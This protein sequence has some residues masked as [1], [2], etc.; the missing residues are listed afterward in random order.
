MKRT[1]LPTTTLLAF[2]LAGSACGKSNDKP[3]DGVAHANTPPGG[4]SA[5]GGNG[6]AAPPKPRPAGA[7][8]SV[9]NLADNRLLAHVQRNGGV[10]ALMG[11]PG[12]AKYLHFAKPKIT[13]KLKQKLDGKAVATA[14]TY[15]DID[16]PLT[17]DQA[18]AAKTVWVRVHSPAAR[19][20]EVK[21]N[22]K[23]A[24]TLDLAAGWQTAQATL[25]AKAA[26]AGENR[27]Q[28]IFGKGAAASVEWIQL[29]GTSAADD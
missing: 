14:E 28:L 15:S 6:K 1:L 10:V 9:F 13:W 21:V 17:A 4:A 29:G 12:V 25:P 8:R 18:E 16:L 24:G 19:K 11:S 5:P 20:M 26:A 7:G 27:V 3:S 22:G 2:V 23:S